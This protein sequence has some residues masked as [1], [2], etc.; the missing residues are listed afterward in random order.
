MPARRLRDCKPRYAID[1]VYTLVGPHQIQLKEEMSTGSLDRVV[2]LKPRPKTHPSV[3]LALVPLL[4]T[5]PARDPL[6]SEIWARI[7]QHTIG[8]EP[9][10]RTACEGQAARLRL[11]LV[12]KSF[13]VCKPCT[14]YLS[15][16]FLFCLKELVLPLLYARPH[17]PTYDNF[18]LFCERVLEADR[19]WDK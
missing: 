7:L 3:T 13:K 6:P 4:P 17:L 12:C 19:R 11:A 14:T 10:A 16:P 2:L 5:R 8:P 15:T 9:D 18:V 1:F